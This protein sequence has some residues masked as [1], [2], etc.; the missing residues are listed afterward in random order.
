MP[1]FSH[2]FTGMVDDAVQVEYSGLSNGSEEIPDEDSGTEKQLYFNRNTVIP[3]LFI[4]TEVV[5]PLPHQADAAPASPLYE[6]QTPP[7][8]LLFL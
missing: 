5:S 1:V 6:I 4:G 7:P 3:N 2:V 8:E